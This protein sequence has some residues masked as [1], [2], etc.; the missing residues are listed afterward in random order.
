[1]MAK[2]KDLIDFEEIKDVID[3]D[4]DL[5]TV[6]GKK[7]IVKDYIISERL[8][9]N[10][11]DIAGNIIKPGHKSVQIIGGYGSG[12]SHLLAWIVSLLENKELVEDITDEDVKSKFEEALK[13]PKA[14]RNTAAAVAILLKLRQNGI[15][16]VAP[17]PCSPASSCWSRSWLE[18]PAL[19]S[20]KIV[21]A[22]K[23]SGQVPG[24]RLAS[25]VRAALSFE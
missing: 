1:M 25:G 15:L 22:A 2:I 23:S 24:S 6:E 4:S 18:R 5:D 20:R 16:I 19:L 12:K 8:K 14:M 9:P 7:N 11:I 3:I 17:L 10:I 13:A 21:R